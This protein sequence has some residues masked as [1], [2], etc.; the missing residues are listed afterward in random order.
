[1]RTKFQEVDL[2]FRFCKEL[3]R[4]Q[5]QILHTDEQTDK[6]LSYGIARLTRNFPRL[7]RNLLRQALLERSPYDTD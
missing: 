5:R 7:T 6:E 3:R 1:M 2:L 4:I